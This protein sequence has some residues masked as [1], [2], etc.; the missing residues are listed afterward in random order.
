M[1][2]SCSSVDSDLL[3]DSVNSC[4]G[5]LDT[6][7]ESESEVDSTPVSDDSSS[8]PTSSS[9][10][11]DSESGLSPRMNKR[12]CIRQP[13]RTSINNHF[14]V[15]ALTPSLAQFDYSQV[16]TDLNA[17]AVDLLQQIELPAYKF[18]LAANCTFK[19]EIEDTDEDSINCWFRS[20]SAVKINDEMLTTLINNAVLEIE[21]QIQNFVQLGS[22]KRLRERSIFFIYNQL[23]NYSFSKYS[24]ILTLRLDISKLYIQYS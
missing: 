24:F 2:E 13:Y 19:R 4:S 6:S 14:K 21:A 16:L 15:Y 20:K 12:K 11:S 18:C 5:F 1:T 23:F 7:S 17:D 8:F 22:G 10:S 9:S 3:S